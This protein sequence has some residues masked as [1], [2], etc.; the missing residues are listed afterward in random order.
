M[1]DEISPQIEESR[2]T[3]ATPSRNKGSC[4]IL[5]RSGVAFATGL[6]FTVARF[7][8]A[9]ELQAF[10]SPVVSGRIGF[11]FRPTLPTSGVEGSN[12]RRS[13]ERLT[14]LQR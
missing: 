7:D 13:A 8:E 14:L 5:L 12:R 6:W 1:R 4:T 10:I 11:T 9:V 3:V 2:P